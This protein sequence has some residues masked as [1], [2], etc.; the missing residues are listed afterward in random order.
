MTVPP[1]K[2]KFRR[3][4]RQFIRVAGPADRVLDVGCA[5]FKFRYLFADKTYTGMDLTV[6]SSAAFF[7]ERWGD[8]FVH[9]DITAQLSDLSDLSDKAFPLTVATHVFAHLSPVSKTAALR[10]LHTLTVAGGVCILQL[11]ESDYQLLADQIK[12][13]FGVEREARYRGVI[14][15]IFETHQILLSFGS[16]SRILSVLCSFFDYGRR[17]SLLLLRKA[18]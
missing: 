16:L 8:T 17:D 18:V 14:S 3:I 1:Y 5:D 11:T 2:Y 13:L 6:P 15:Q 10:N 9:G 7:R 4:L 12:T